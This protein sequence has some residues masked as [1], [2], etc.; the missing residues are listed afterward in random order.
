[1]AAVIAKC[2]HHDPLYLS[3]IQVIY[4][5]YFL[6]SENPFSKVIY[7]DKILHI[8][9]LYGWIFTEAIQVKYLAQITNKQCQLG[10]HIFNFYLCLLSM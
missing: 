6:A 1:M 8:I 4:G 3:N 2:L 7:A 9:H 5:C 10:F